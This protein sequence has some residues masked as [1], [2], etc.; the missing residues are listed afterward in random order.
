[1]SDLNKEKFLREIAG[2]GLN[3]YDVA[4]WRK[5][6]AWQQRL[7]PSSRCNNS[8][9][10]S[11]AFVVTAIGML[12]DEGKLSVQDPICRLFAHEMPP[13]ADPGWR[14]MRVEHALTHT[15]GFG[16]GFLD[17]DVVRANTF[18]SEDYLG[19]V[20][21]HPL[22]YVPGTVPVYSDAAFYLLS[23]VVSKAAGENLDTFLMD[24]LFRPLHFSEAAWSLCPYHY[25]IGATGLYISSEDML[26][27]AVLYLQNGLWEG[28]RILSEAW[29]Q[30]VI[31]NEYEF[32]T[33]TPGGLIGKCG[34]YG[35]GLV[36]HR[37][38]ELAAAWHG[39]SS[40][41]SVEKL[42]AY[43]EALP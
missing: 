3:L 14:V 31:A 25:P 19:M 11:K 41:E 17:V 30:K 29:V 2:F 40:D 38:K 37:E 28:R 26:K 20:L 35:Q 5:G 9:S 15:C 16:E 42:I 12:W 4:L 18:P 1:M 6:E 27:L 33:M 34:M 8:Y 13:D 10:V 22:R 32:H 24:R 7:Q 39:H 21:S 36:F 23:R 43:L